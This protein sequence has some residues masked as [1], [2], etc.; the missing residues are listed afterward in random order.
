VRSTFGESLLVFIALL[1]AGA[2][3]AKPDTLVG[4][5]LTSWNPNFLYSQKTYV[6]GVYYW[7]NNS[8]DGSQSNIGWCLIGEA[9]CGLSNAPGAIP[10][11][12]N[13][14]AAPASMYFSSSGNAASITLNLTSTDQKGI[15][16]GIDLFGI[17]LTNAAGTAIIDPTVI[18]TSNDAIGNRYTWATGALTAGQDYG[19]FIENVQGIGTPDV[20]YYTYYMN[21]ALNV[22]TGSMPADNLQHF[23]AFSSGSNYY[24]G[25]VDADSCRGSYLPG[26]TPCIPSSEFDYNDFVIELS[27]TQSQSPAPEPASSALLLV[28]GL[29]AAL[30]FRFKSRR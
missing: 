3:P 14:G 6:P 15:G 25:A 29:I 26:V 4:G 8:G 20:T 24:I 16:H 21:S 28:G 22:A 23:A 18:F 27:T 17:Y 13:K 19:F 2:A 12:S 1:V 7:N 30:S 5:T 10:F 9:Q 11:Y